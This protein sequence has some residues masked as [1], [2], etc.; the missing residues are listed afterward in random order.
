MAEVDF[1]TQKSVVKDIIALFVNKS[2]DVLTTATSKQLE[3]DIIE[4]IEGSNFDKNSINDFIDIEVNIGGFFEGSIHLYMDKPLVARLSDLMMMGDGQAEYTDDFNEAISELISQVVGGFSTDISSQYGSSIENKGVKAE[5]VNLEQVNLEGGMVYKVIIKMED[6]EDKEFFI[7]VD[8]NTMDNI[9]NA[10]SSSLDEV[11]KGGSSS[12]NSTTQK[13]VSQALSELDSISDGDIIKQAQY[14]NLDSESNL[15]SDKISNIQYL[16]DIELDIAIEL[17][18]TKMTIKDI[19]E[20]TNGS[21]IELN[22]LAGEPVDVLVNGKVIA[23]GE[24]IVIDE[25]FGVRLTSLV[26]PEE[27]LKSLR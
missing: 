17:G 21:I 16:L 4:E 7:A 20:L 19:L 1:E 9:V 18:R 11:M 22:R 23:R 5:A 24:V 25:N 2:V 12:D 6:F 27:R 13:N 14:A 10:I 15:P 8:K 26:S 3:L